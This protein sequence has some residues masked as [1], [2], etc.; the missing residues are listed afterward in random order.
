MFAKP[1]ERKSTARKITNAK[2][3]RKAPKV[4]RRY[5]KPSARVSAIFLK[6]VRG[7]VIS[8]YGPLKNGTQNDGI[9]ISAKEGT[10]VKAAENGV[11]VYCGRDIPSYGNLV[12]V[13]HADG[14]VSTYGHLKNIAVKRGI[15]IKRGQTVGA[16]GTSGHV[17]QPQLHFELRKG[18]YPVNLRR[19]CPSEGFT[20]FLIILRVAGIICVSI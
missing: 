10:P 7:K 17:K 8:H 5:A 20:R 3:W 16:I 12:L 14:W 13:K 19:I 1:S 15:K 2:S 11:V 6:P 18:R 9:N 4:K